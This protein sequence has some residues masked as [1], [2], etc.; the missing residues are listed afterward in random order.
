MMEEVKAVGSALSVHG[1]NVKVT[2]VVKDGDVLT[3]LIVSQ[4]L[5]GTG[6]YHVH[7]TY[8]DFEWLQQHL[9]SQ[10]E[11]LGIQGVI[12][13]PLPGKAQVNTPAKVLKQLG[14]LGLGEWRLY[15]RAL[16]TFLRQI[17]THTI[18]GKNKAVEIFLTSSEPP[19]GQRT[20]KNIFNRLSQ[21]VEEM[22]KE[23]HKD[24]DEFFQ[25]EREHNHLLTGCCKTAAEKFLDV[26][27]TEQ[28]IAVACG[29]FAAA[30]QL[31]VEPGED[32]DKQAFTHACVKLS[33]VFECMKR[34]M[35]SV[36]ENNASTLGL[37]LDLDYRYQEAEKEMLFR[38]TCKL[39]EVETARKNVEKAKPIKKTAMEEVLKAAQTDFEQISSVA[40]KEITRLQGARVEMLQQ[41]LVQLCEKQLLTAKENADQFNRQL[42]AF[43]GMA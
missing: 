28:K 25:T 16:E 37:S 41:A 19:G 29:H 2:E 42:Q 17:A 26:V 15:C 24:V 12:F 20:K 6:E 31:C 21:A 10:E 34:N 5:T 33:Q 43:R 13:P 36:A 39:V 1:H 18:L 9:F 30:L 14:F 23:G 4:K 35:A 22:R 27:Q 38:R 8:D 40:K 32:P 11:E 3:F 7:R